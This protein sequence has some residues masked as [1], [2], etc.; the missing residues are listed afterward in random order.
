MTQTYLD[1]VLR[2]LAA[3]GDGFKVMNARLETD[4]LVN[5]N[6][7]LV[8]HAYIQRDRVPDLDGEA[9]SH[10][11]SERRPLCGAELSNRHGRIVSIEA[12]PVLLYRQSAENIGAALAA[13]S[14][15]SVADANNEAR[16]AAQRL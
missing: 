8:F 10:R 2:L 3:K 16:Y 15:K 12:K 1:R 9:R 7:R 13:E 14:G 4:P 6:G 5:A 11:L